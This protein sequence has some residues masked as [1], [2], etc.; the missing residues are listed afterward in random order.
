MKNLEKIGMC[1][2]YKGY[3]YWKRAAQIA[4]K[5]KFHMTHIYEKLAEEFNTTPGAI[6]RGMATALR[7]ITNIE[8]K[9]KVDY[10]ITQKKFLGWL[11][12]K[13]VE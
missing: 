13:G 3:E 7:N 6:Q 10:T 2:S 9:L 12:Y 11:V 4:K 8:K 5:E 1:P